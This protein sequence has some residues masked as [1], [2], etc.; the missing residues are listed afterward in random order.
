MTNHV[1]P[2]K[3]LL[4]EAA[5]AA[6]RKLLVKRARIARSYASQVPVGHPATRTQIPN[7]K[8]IGWLGSRVVSVLDS[9]AAGPGFKS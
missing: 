6:A 7:P 4:A 9:G 3:C 5:A 8:P 1:T 2:G